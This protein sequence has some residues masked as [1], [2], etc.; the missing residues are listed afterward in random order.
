METKWWKSNNTWQK[1]LCC[2]MNNVDLQIPAELK[3][4]PAWNSLR[5]RFSKTLSCQLCGKWAHLQKNPEDGSTEGQSVAHKH[6]LSRQMKHKHYRD[7]ST[8][9]YLLFSTWFEKEKEGRKDILVINYEFCF[10]QSVGLQLQYWSLSRF[11]AQWWG[12]GT[13]WQGLHR[14]K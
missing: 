9:T 6:P 11:S 10:L 5:H 1:A 2:S 14:I 4:T 13:E 12:F 8:F 3:V 7:D